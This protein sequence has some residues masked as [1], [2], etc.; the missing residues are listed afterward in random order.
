MARVIADEVMDAASLQ[1][2]Y[3]KCKAND[4]CFISLKPVGEARV[5]V[6]HPVFGNVAVKPQFVHYP[7]SVKLG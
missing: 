7:S 2:R 4:L 5:V 1:A 3:E 6:A